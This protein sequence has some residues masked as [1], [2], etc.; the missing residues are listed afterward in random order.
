VLDFGLVKALEQEEE[1][2]LTSTGQVLGTPQYMPPEQAGGE[3]VDQRSDLFS[4]TGVFYYCLTGHSPYG[5]NSV[6]KALTLALAG[7]VPLIS[8]YRQ[9]AP[10]PKSIDEFMLKG[11]MPEKEDRFQ[12]AEDFIQN[13]HAA[14]SG[15]PDSVLDAV[16]VFTPEAAEGGTGSSSASRK[17]A[18]R[19]RAPSKAISAVSRPLPKSSSRIENAPGSEPVI[20]RKQPSQSQGSGSQSRAAPQGVPLG[21]LVA[22]VAGLVLL[23]GG[24]VAWK[25]LSKPT[26]VV[27]AQPPIAKPVPPKPVEDAPVKAEPAAMIKVTLKTTPEGAEVSEDGVTIGNAP[28]TVDWQRGATRTF[29]FKL[30]G[31]KDLS[32]TLRSEAD[33]TF[34]FNLEPARSKPV[35][36]SKKPPP[37]KDPE[38]GAFD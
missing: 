21:V 13:L 25:Q 36:G 1:E 17:S 5:A 16:P 18:S 22:I 6:R 28:V 12:T 4:L 10:V 31:H 26:E 11:L 20:D 14:L 23:I 37:K 15:A 38:M 8:T 35:D 30:A 32:K 9:G 34:D 2:Q 19:S 29:T 3:V 27:E 33:Q 24:A 7:N